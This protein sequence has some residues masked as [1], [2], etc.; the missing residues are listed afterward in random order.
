MTTHPLNV[1]RHNGAVGDARKNDQTVP[2]Y[3]RDD[4]PSGIAARRTIANYLR[5]EVDTALDLDSHV[6]TLGA[7][8]DTLLESHPT[9]PVTAAEL[10]DALAFALSAEVG[11]DYGVRRHAY[12]LASC[13]APLFK[14]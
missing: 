6:E 2:G 7:T 3:V 8:I 11:M 5:H 9:A 14:G 10:V 12:V 13:L 4:E 1:R